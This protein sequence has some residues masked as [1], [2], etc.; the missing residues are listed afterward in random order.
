M[1]STQT[2]VIQSN[3]PPT[4]THLLLNKLQGVSA[5]SD[6]EPHKA[7][8]RMLILRNED[9]LL[10]PTDWRPA[11]GGG[12][13]WEGGEKR[14]GGGEMERGAEERKRKGKKE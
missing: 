8:L 11:K 7:D 9:L 13:G 4:S 5:R 3:S 10:V 1:T 6:D 14:R 2:I 12:E